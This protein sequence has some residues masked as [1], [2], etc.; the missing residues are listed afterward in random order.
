MCSLGIS[1]MCVGAFGSRSRK[2]TTRSDSRRIS[3]G[4]SRAAILQKM[5]LLSY[6]PRA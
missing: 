1:R 3:A 2:A 4:I 5:Q 6:M